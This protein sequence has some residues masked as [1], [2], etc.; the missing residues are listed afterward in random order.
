[1]GS[2][3]LGAS[4]LTTA[5]GIS[6]LFACG[7][8][9][10]PSA[11]GP[12]VD[13]SGTSSADGGSDA[14][15]P[16][17]RAEFGLD[18]RPANPTCK[19]PPRPPSTVSVKLERV[20]SNVRLAAPMM[21]AQAP[22]DAS[23]FYVA[24]RD[25]RIVSFAAQNPG[26]DPTVVANLAPLSGKAVQQGGEGGL[27]GFAF[28]PGFAQNGRLYVSWVTTGGPANFRSEIG[29]LTRPQGSATFTT[30]ET[31]LGPF[32]QPA[33]NHN[34]G[35]IAFGK[36]G[37]L[38]VS[39]GD[40]GG[41]GDTYDKGQTTDGFFSK[42]LRI[43]VDAPSGGRKYGIPKA[44][45]FAQGGGEPATY[46]MGFRNPF[47]ISIDRETGELWVGDVG[48][49]A[50]EEIDRVKLGGNYGWPCREGLH[51]FAP[52]KCAA[53]TTLQDPVWEHA[54]PE[55]QSMTGGVVYRGKAIPALVG[56]YVYGDYQTQRVHVLTFDP[57]TGAPKS[58]RVNDAGPTADWVDFAEDAE[59]EVY[60]V[61]IGQGSIYKVANA[62]T[63]SGGAP[64][65]DRLSK[66]GCVDAKDPRRAAPGV[67]PYAPNSPLWSDGATKD[68]WIALPDGKTVDVMDDG[69]FAFPI[70]TVLGKTFSLAG[71][72]IETRLFIRHEDGEWGGY[73]YEWLDDQTDAVLLP[74]SKSKSVGTQ[75]WYYPSRAE[76]TR[77]HTAAAGR[78]LGLELGQQNGDFVYASTNLIANQLKT[79]DHIGVF[80]TP[81][82]KPVD[83]IVAYP[84]PLE[85]GPL[86]PR[87]R[88]YLHANC[89]VC[90]RP[91]GGGRG[92]MDLRF[93][94]PLK[95]AALCNAT[96]EAGD[97]GIA[98]AKLLAPGKPEA[99]LVHVRPS[100]SGANRMPPLASAVVD[101][102]GTA[103]LASWIQ[104]L[105]ACP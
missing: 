67:I 103:L 51:D 35:G 78:S 105:T 97:L 3:R 53:G 99:S 8:D 52:G 28:H 36:D 68:R 81:L 49:D 10:D 57:V 74:G 29:V 63:V 27:L 73:T 84:K 50:W 43:D 7:K 1:M 58:T 39:F 61:A 15:P 79:L 75:T 32:D 92:A 42:V 4:L 77:C 34:G 91:E 17:T 9:D 66:T 24:L 11:R 101:T 55:F 38:Y 87:A 23:R 65:P 37:L 59:G 70:G 83:Q 40:G 72:R 69:D 33:S 44:N 80:T 96:P 82:G 22:G 95:D 102:Q 30:Y 93:G 94:T 104:G 76:C 5:L 26:N 86:E 12:N 62:D 16:P 64:F 18:S 90:H 89:S 48:Q 56:A 88:A 98:G 13:P 54:Q 100:A 19:A 20:F 47:R 6:A 60:G 85:D 41:G 71:Q 25:G 46:A 21:L 14:T 45:P 2:S 31:I